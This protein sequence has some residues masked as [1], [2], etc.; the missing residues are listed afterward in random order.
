MSTSSDK[1]TIQFN[2]DLFKIPEKRNT[3][4]RNSSPKEIKVRSGKT[5]RTHLIR[6]IRNLQEERYKRMHENSNLTENNEIAPPVP[7][8]SSLSSPSD[9]FE[10][11]FDHSLQFLKNM[12]EEEKS[13]SSAAAAKPPSHSSTLR[14]SPYAS[15]PA[16][17][18]ISPTG[19]KYYSQTY[20]LGV[21]SPHNYEID[22]EVPAEL[23]RA[24]NTPPIKLTP[25]HPAP[26]YGVLKNGKLPTYRQFHNITQRNM[27]S[28]GGQGNTNNAVTSNGGMGSSNITVNKPQELLSQIKMHNTVQEA[29]M[30]GAGA[31]LVKRPKKQRRIVKRTF[32]V[33]KS[34]VYPKV[35]V[36]VAN[37]TIRNNLA[38]RIQEIKRT[39]IEQVKRDLVKRG[40]IKVG[41]SA[42]NDVL[43][44]M[45][46][47]V[48]M[49]Y[50]EVK[51]HNSE[52]LLYNYLNADII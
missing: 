3:R 21:S 23:N 20:D 25:K 34:K 47:S 31:G 32:R 5:S 38:T 10:S 17:P 49:I 27:P 24:L 6:Q 45:Y 50:G 13:L 43:R 2:P 28:S 40:L 1:K 9:N 30:R 16:P 52:N 42:P 41:S 7:S 8:S 14:N 51:N 33:G 19:S 29:N 12:V 37:K 15:S 18:I 4:K 44:K 26:Q 46:E 39:P 11:D 36:L 22:L 35:G 48:S